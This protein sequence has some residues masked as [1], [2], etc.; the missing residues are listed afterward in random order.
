[1]NLSKY[2]SNSNRHLLVEEYI[3][4]NHIDAFEDMIQQVESDDFNIEKFNLKYSI[5]VES[6]LNNLLDEDITVD[7]KLGSLNIIDSNNKEYTLPPFHNT[8]NGKQIMN[9]VEPIFDVST[10]Q[11]L[12]ERVNAKIYKSMTYLKDVEY[13]KSDMDYNI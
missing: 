11:F 13:N 10:E 7:V 4:N 8:K 3:Y 9:G 2:L 5:I 1:M 6:L 12:V